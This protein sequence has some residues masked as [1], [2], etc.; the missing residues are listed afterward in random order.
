MPLIQHV[1]LPLP[2]EQPTITESQAPSPHIGG[3]GE[4]NV[5][6]PPSNNS[7]PPTQ[8]NL[9]FNIHEQLDFADPRTKLPELSRG[10]LDNALG[11]DPVYSENIM[12]AF[13]KIIVM[14]RDWNPE[15]DFC[16]LLSS[17]DVDSL[18]QE[19]LRHGENPAKILQKSEWLYRYPEIERLFP[20]QSQLSSR[21]PTYFES[22]LQLPHPVEQSFVGITD[23]PPGKKWVS[24]RF[25]AGNP[26]VEFRASKSVCQLYENHR[27]HIDFLNQKLPAVLKF[28]GHADR[29]V[30]KENTKWVAIDSNCSDGPVSV[31][32]LLDSSRCAKQ[33]LSP[34][35]PMA[36]SLKPQDLLNSLHD[37]LRAVQD[38]LFGS[39]IW[40]ARTNA[41]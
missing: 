8:L 3:A 25:W 14:E 40:P 13:V 24:T 39:E 32:S 37:V 38:D 6:L 30:E 4:P 20:M 36:L 9:L 26:T 18:A 22:P 19:H 41:E 35:I 31:G 7:V 21:P 11:A 33:D 10:E 2:T 1:F 28:W 27:M 5:A 12:A 16:L 17:L 34:P 15:H 29:V 23:V